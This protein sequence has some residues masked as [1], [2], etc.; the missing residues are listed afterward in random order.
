MTNT[1]YIT[2]TFRPELVTVADKLHGVNTQK[3]DEPCQCCL[4]ERCTRIYRA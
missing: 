4:Q 3:R 1:Q 2:T